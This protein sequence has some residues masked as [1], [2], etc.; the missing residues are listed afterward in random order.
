MNQSIVIKEEGPMS[1]SQIHIK[2]LSSKVKLSQDAEGESKVEKRKM[3]VARQSAKSPLNTFAM[4][5]ST[6]LSA[7]KLPGS[8]AK[9]L[10]ANMIQQK[11]VLKP[12]A[13]SQVQAG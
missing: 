3:I 7:A 1:A 10:K 2:R 5:K 8:G 4:K 13:S 6:Q 9:P 12:S 11:S